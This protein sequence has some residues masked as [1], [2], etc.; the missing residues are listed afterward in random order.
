MKI[1]TTEDISTI[2]RYAVYGAIGGFIS[3]VL[4]SLAS[5]SAPEFVITLSVSSA[6]AAWFSGAQA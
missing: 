6:V 1:I 3:A 5:F 2:K 4:A